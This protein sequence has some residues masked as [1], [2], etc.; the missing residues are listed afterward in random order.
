MELVLPN[1]L[2]LRRILQWA[3]MSP[4]Q[5]RVLFMSIRTPGLMLLATSTQQSIKYMKRR[6]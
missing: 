5:H 2:V 1:L 4:L 3:A 6:P